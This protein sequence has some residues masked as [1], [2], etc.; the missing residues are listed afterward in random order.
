MQLP[1]AC[2]LLTTRWGMDSPF[3]L[4]ESQ[5][6]FR[7]TMRRFAD[8]R[9]A[10]Q[11]AEA[12]RNA[13]FPKASFDACVE[14]ELPALGLPVEYGG[15]GADTV[16]QAVMAEELARV[17]ASTCL[18][19]LISKLA[20]VPILQFGTEELKRRYVPQVASGAHTGQLLPVRGGCRQRHCRHAGPGRA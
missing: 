19:L 12:D 9:I 15:A 6:D 11:A 7:D 2:R 20:M 4:S 10:P 8:E 5:R 13:S 18:T 1:V 3:G 17:C 16:T 14:L